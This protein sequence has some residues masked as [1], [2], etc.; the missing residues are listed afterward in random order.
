MG[1][2]KQL[3]LLTERNLI[4]FLISISLGQLP[5]DIVCL[6]HGQVQNDVM[7]QM[8]LRFKKLSRD[9]RQQ[10]QDAYIWMDWFSIPYLG[11]LHL[12]FQLYG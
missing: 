8:M 11:S 5:L 10:L 7:T 2:L 3:S 1:Q 4:N 6:P 9:Q 12:F